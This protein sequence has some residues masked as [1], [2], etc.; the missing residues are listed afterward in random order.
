MTVAELI[1]QLQKY[2][3]D[4]EIVYNDS[5]GFFTDV[6]GSGI[7]FE[8]SILDCSRKTIVIIY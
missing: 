8:H 3:S 4:A 1:E 5:M 2:P 7:E 6:T